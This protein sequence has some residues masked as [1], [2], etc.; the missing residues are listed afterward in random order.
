MSTSFDT[1]STPAE[2]AAAPVKD[3]LQLNMEVSKPH[4]CLR[5]VVV[6]IPRGEVDRY[7]KDAYDELV[8]EAQVPGFR[9]GRAPRKLVEK[10]FKDRIE[11]RVKG[12][13]L[14]DSLAKVTEDAEFSAIGEPDF[15]YDSI[16][17][18]E[19][20]DFKY[21]FSIEVRPEFA[22]PD[23][24]KLEL[25]KPVETISDDDVA[26][27][28]QRV[29]SRYASL[30]ASD[31]PAELGDRL[32]LTA[33]FK[34]GDKV[35]SEMEEERVTLANRLSLSDAVCENFGEMMKDCK[36][37]DVVTGKVK[38][39]EGHADEEM[40][41]KE[42]DATFTVVEVLKEQ[43]PELTAEFLDELGE[44]E[45]EDELRDFVRQSLER[46]ANFRT[47]QAMRGAIVEKLLEAADFDLP[48]TLVRRQMKRE[49]DR[50]VLEFRRSG[51]DDDMIR[52]FVNATKQNMQEGTEA[53]LREHFI[54]EQIADEEK[55]DAE[56]QEY[57]DE[58]ML[59]A[60]Q[61]D[62][63][64]RRVRARLEKTGQM[65]ALRNQI[66]ERKVIEL[67]TEAATVTDEP[68]EKESEAANE[69][70]AVYHEV[71]PTKDHDAIPEAKY[72]DNTPKGAEP[73]EKEKD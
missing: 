43:L 19:T 72:D 29:L 25:K 13:L 1:D 27:A 7:M 34:D 63:S 55:I 69:E 71:V 62:S 33:V 32:L 30:E 5:E 40:K 68:V 3:P 49:L 10:Q 54:L 64:P 45:S 52:R 42:L 35:V 8:P 15:A 4:A 51:F 58:I 14:M 31:A 12:S 17:L 21:Q 24:K 66:V 38:L 36:E 57:E 50:K 56:P 60:E 61:S 2:D 37:G 41:G 73:E 18:P 20:G 53:S 16:K 47:E 26:A 28:L 9:A 59:I 6:T 67:I 22:T 70:F 46:Q 65:D 23:W 44:F 48:P 11:D 39:S